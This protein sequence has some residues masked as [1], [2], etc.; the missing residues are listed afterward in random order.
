MLVVLPGWA[1]A[2]TSIHV[3]DNG[4]EPR[5]EHRRASETPVAAVVSV[6]SGR[7]VLLAVRKGWR[8]VPSSL[9]VAALAAAWLVVLVPMIAKRRQEVVR[10]ADSALAARVLR[11]DGARSEI[12]EVPPMSDDVDNGTV[13][14]A[15]AQSRRYRPGRGG[16]DPEAAELEARA[17]YAFRQ[18]TVLGLLIVA[19]TSAVLAAL[20]TPVLW[21]LHVAVDLVVVGYL[22]YLRRQ[23]RIEE[24]IRRRRTARLAARECRAPRRAEQPEEFDA[25]PEAAPERAPTARPVR[26]PSAV[27]V[28]ADD[29]DPAFDDLDG[30]LPAY[31]RA[32]GE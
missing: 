19:V 25:T 10:T 28:E 12:E 30:P 8:G 2:P 26:H 6:V 3:A 24:D 22:S 23:V 21:W 4:G 9:I 13:A 31:G 17:K 16:F 32:A 29:E 1:L 11:R 15:T 14:G 20:V 27:A 7:E 5:R 18:R